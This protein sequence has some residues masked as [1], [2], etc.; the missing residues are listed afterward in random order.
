LRF[1]E[2]GEIQRIGAEGQHRHVNVRVI[3]ATNR[4]LYERTQQKEFREDL[5]YRLNV[6]ELVVPPLRA[7][8]EDARLLFEHFLRVMSEQYRL[9]PCQMSTEAYGQLEAY[10]WPGNVRELKNIAERVAVR[11]P[12]QLLTTLPLPVMSHPAIPQPPRAGLA[13][14]VLAQTTA[15]LYDRMAAHGESFWTVVSEPFVAR[16]LTREVVRA[17]VARGLLQTRGS[18]KLLASLFNCPATDYKRFLNFLNKHECHVGFQRFRAMERPP[19]VF[20]ERIA[21]TNVG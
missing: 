18:Y 2:T 6:V 19:L 12:G 11:S 15:D 4:D 10:H 7:R 9:P 20:P 13:A 21:Q 8:P 3:A 16:D 5:Y 14:M 1:F 17:I